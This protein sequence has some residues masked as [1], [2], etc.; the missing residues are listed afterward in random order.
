MTI[1]CKL[2]AFPTSWARQN[3][4]IARLLPLEDKIRYDN[5]LYRLVSDYQQLV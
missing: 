3:L 4:N 1:F 5:T 2:I